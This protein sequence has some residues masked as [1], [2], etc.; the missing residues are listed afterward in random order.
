[1]HRI[2][3]TYDNV[4]STAKTYRLETQQNGYL[5]YF[6]AH[7]PTGI[8]EV[9]PNKRLITPNLYTNIDLE[10]SSNQNGIKYY[11][12]I[13]P[14]GTPTN[15]KLTFTGTSSF[16]LDGS[17]NVL[18]ISSAVG[19][20]K[21]DRPTVYQL[22]STNTIIPITGWT[23]D[24][25][26]NGGTGKYKFNIGAYDNTKPLIIEVDEGNSA[27][28]MST[29]TSNLNW[30]TYVV[31]TEKSIC[32]MPKPV[33]LQIYFV[34]G[35]CSNNNFPVSPGSYSGTNMGSYDATATKFNPA[36]AML[37]STFIGGTGMDIGY[38]LRMMGRICLLSRWQFV[39]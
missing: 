9:Y 7:I 24:W 35:M 26:T 32:L 29:T 21:F 1:M 27:L 18:T 36:G 34:S 13:K 17:S 38:V 11:Y 8:T 3:L 4:S 30:S 2:D 33:L 22:S 16:N 25:Q 39:N 15:I 12:I 20:I 31:V 6:L 37:W 19:K 23:A 5:N 10:Y 28:A 14:G